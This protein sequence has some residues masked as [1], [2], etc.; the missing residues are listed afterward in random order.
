MA[1]LAFVAPPFLGHLNPMRALARELVGRGHHATFLGLADMGP[2]VADDAIGFRPVGMTTHPR[3]TLVA[4]TRRMAAIDGVIGLPGIIRDVAGATD[5]LARDLPAALR[6]I[7]ADL[8]VCDGTEAAGG[9]VAEHL[10]L[11]FV[12]VANALPLNREP[13]VPPPFTGWRYDAAPSAVKRNVGGYRVSD[14]L[15]RRHGD[16][17]AAH[18]ARLRLPP[19]RDL[20]S[21]LSPFAQIGQLV[22]G[23]DFPRSRLP[24]VFH[25]CGPFRE[26]GQGRLDADLP[27]HDGRPRAYASLG[28]LQGGRLGLMRRIAE[29]G[30]RLDLQLIVSHGGGLSEA[31]AAA[32]PGAPAAFRWVPQD[33]ALQGA[34][35]AMVNGGLNTV[36]DALARG[37]PIVVVP[38]AFE[39]AAI[40]ARLERAGAGRSVRRR[41]LTAGRLARAVRHVLD[42]PTYASAAS[43]LAAEIAGAGGVRR[44]AD[45]VEAVLT[46]GRSVLRSEAAEAVSRP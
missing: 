36:L 32:L 1:H 7:G 42:N 4:M 10:R 19:R 45:I 21:C 15:M 41:F 5:M 28:S 22:A 6:G 16:I 17:I 14:W 29:A 33:R 20:D 43:R 31:Q 27:P 40:A 3:G 8:V 30:R 2:L 37:V 26:P 34:A 9:L 35:V 13:G 12:T 23:L 46:T 25:Y 11:P 38:I 18:A 39:Q 44:A 24:E